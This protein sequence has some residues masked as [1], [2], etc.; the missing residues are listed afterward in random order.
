MA[1][2]QPV[3]RHRIQLADAEVRRVRKIDDG[4][5][6][7]V[8][9][10]LHPL[11]R[12]G[13]DH[14]HA[15]VA[16]RMLVKR[17]QCLGVREQVRHA[18]VQ[19]DQRDVLHLR[20]LQDLPQREAV[21]AA[22]HQHAPR[23][24]HRFQRRQYQRLVIAVFV[25]RG[26]LQ[27]TVDVQAQVVF[28]ACHHQPL[29]RRG[30]RMDDLVA[31]ERA[32]RPMRELV[33]CTKARKQCRCHCAGAPRHRRAHA[34]RERQLGAEVPERP[35]RN[36]RI[37]QSEQETGAHQPQAR[38]QYQRKQQRHRQGTQVIERQHA[39]D[40]VGELGLPPMQH[41]HHQRD[42]HA[43]QHADHRDQRVQHQAERRRFQRKQRKQRR[44]RYAAKQ[45]DQQFQID[46]AGEQRLVGHVA[47]EP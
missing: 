45:P 19:V 40:E 26:K 8:G 35:D 17:D 31:K 43:H 9:G 44:R 20:V 18:R 41:A 11:R 38:R 36:R 7:H 27:V 6:E 13:V 32:F 14:C 12:I 4:H 47:G 1:R 33:R 39:A 46:K 22:Q 30:N 37:E 16:E 34:G 28:P 15:W 25:A 10:G 21:A 3:E 29:I 2:Q 42:L 23:T 24:A 5:V